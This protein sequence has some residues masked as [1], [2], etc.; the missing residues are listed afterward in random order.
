[1]D[2]DWEMWGQSV[3][4]LLAPHSGVEGGGKRTGA[5]LARMQQTHAVLRDSVHFLE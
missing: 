2:L 1:M 3:S 5:A 4:I